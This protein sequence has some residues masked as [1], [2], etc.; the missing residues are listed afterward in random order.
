MS[1]FMPGDSKKRLRWLSITVIVMS[2]IFTF[3]LVQFQVVQADQLNK[4]LL[5]KLSETR[6]IPAL[7]GRIIDV[8]GKVLA[9]TVF[10][11]DV[12]AAPDI[13]K[14]F[15]RVV[16]GRTQLINVQQAASEIAAILKM[17]PA[18]VVLKITGTSKY[19][20]I[21]KKVDAGSYRRLQALNV[22]W[23]FYDALPHR[24]YPSGAVAGNIIGFVGSDG[25]A[26]AGLEL[27]MN[28]CLTGVDGLE[29]YEKGVDGI[30]IPASSQ[31]TK[32]A[33][34]GSDV[35]LTINSD[36]QY[37]AQQVMAQY[38]KSEKADWGSAV[39]V[40]A[41]T[42][43]I[44][45]AA[46]APTVDPN[47]PGASSEPDRRSRVFQA[48]FEP[49][50][51]MKT[52]TAA[53][54][55]DAGAATPTS[56][57]KAPQT[58]KVLNGTETIN[59]SHNHPLE[60]LTLTGVLK[61]SS[62]TGI[63]QL[64]EVVPLATRYAYLQ[65][66]G[67]GAKTAVNFE[68]E[69]GGEFPNYKTWDGLTS[70]T[71]MFGQG[72]SV[73]PI[74]TAFFYQTVANG[75]VRLPAQLVQGCRDE[76]GTLVQLPTQEPV[77]VVSK[78]SA[79]STLDMLE[80]VVEQGGIGRTAA[81]PGYRIAGKSGTAQTKQGSGYGNRYAIS[82]IGVAPADSPKYVLAVTIYRP[83]TVSN[84]IGATP[85]FKAIMEQ[86]L[87]MYRVPPSTTKSKNIPTNW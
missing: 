47:D 57:V 68:G 9:K 17:D 74:Q 13:V 24:V 5:N 33:K 79:R 63:V 23:L 2:V 37:Y 60:H 34:N 12:N 3:R 59:D 42:G 22:P 72:L 32:E 58:L 56:Q 55:I 85:P 1:S 31:I 67:L 78:A 66:F 15:E 84:S 73:T 51:T 64:G 11:Y 29:T 46:E 25:D 52:V 30:K 69:S 86:L 14:P 45:A 81:V 77:N 61:E 80:K 62:N 10:E 76:A 36:L 26:L 35:I 27:T 38:V 53:I 6:V 71:S 43:K 21:Q 39:I 50:S 49:G 19:S 4:D 54:A 20:N 40:E 28:S 75:G 16:N 18:E 70:L 83:K 82:F 7:R 48:T 44:L 87:R 8:N 41:K 65:K